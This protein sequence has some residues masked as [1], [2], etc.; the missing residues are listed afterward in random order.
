MKEKREALLIA[1]VLGALILGL[2]LWYMATH[3]APVRAP[4][5][6]EPE[7]RVET[8]QGP[9]HRIT[10][11]FPSNIVLP[12]ASDSAAGGRVEGVM[13]QW[14]NETIATF[15]SESR[16]EELTPEEAEYLRLVDGRKYTL[17]I[18]YEMYFSRT[19]QS[20]VFTLFQDTL[21]AHPLTFYKT[22]TFD[23]STGNEMVLAD[24]FVP[25]SDY[26]GAL[27]R[28]SREKLPQIISDRQQSAANMD[29]LESGTTPDEMNFKTYVVDGNVLVL[30]FPPYQVGPYVLG[31]ITLP[32][33]FEELGDIVRPEYLEA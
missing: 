33:P 30:I 9:Y 7:T 26:V 28:I 1:G 32:I 22:F 18:T 14:L 24:L 25:G 12:L 4:L 13:T 29:Y 10:V 6:M 11:E 15:K 20:Y 16:V 5:T 2:S 27:S 31:T 21:G 3:P 19:T 17:D 23:A 8:D